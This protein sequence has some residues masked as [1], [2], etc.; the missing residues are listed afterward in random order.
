MKSYPVSLPNG[1]MRPNGT[2][3]DSVNIR[4]LDGRDEDFLADEDSSTGGEPL[5]HQL[6]QRTIL[7]YGDDL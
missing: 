6:L 2:K 1:F 5:E 3:C 7:S 4:K